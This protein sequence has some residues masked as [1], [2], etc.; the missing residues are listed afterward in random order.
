MRLSTLFPV[1]LLA[2]MA[3][4]CTVEP[5][6]DGVN[7]QLHEPFTPSKWNVN[8]KATANGENACTVSSG[9]GGITFVVRHTANGNVVSVQSNRF[10]PMGT[11]LTVTLNGHRYE[12]SDPYFSSKDAVAMVEDFSA[13]DKAFADWSELKAY[14]GRTHYTAEYILAG[15][16]QKID[17][18]QK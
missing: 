9:Y 3:A 7:A 10:M 8:S 6:G 15:F 1:T 16:R 12:T 14:N 13:G 17:Q 5:S 18:C 4:A 11:T 2:L